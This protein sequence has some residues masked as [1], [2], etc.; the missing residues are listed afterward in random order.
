MVV[1]CRAT[2]DSRV[3]WITGGGTVDGHAAM[4]FT[5]APNPSPGTRERDPSSWEGPVET[6]P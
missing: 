2:V 5:V 1:A 4:T 3:S 6:R